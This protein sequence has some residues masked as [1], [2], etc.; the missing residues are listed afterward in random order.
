MEF[1]DRRP[2]KGQLDFWGGE[3]PGEPAQPASTDPAR[4]RR[5]ATK[6]AAHARHGSYEKR[7][8]DEEWGD[9]ADPGEGHHGLPQAG[10]MNLHTELGIKPG[11]PP[12][13]ATYH[14]SSPSARLKHSRVEEVPIQDANGPTIKTHQPEVSAQRLHELFEHPETGSNP[15]LGRTE[16]PYAYHDPFIGE[17]TVID[18]THRTAK[19]VAQN[20]MFQPMRVYDDRSRD[21][22]TAHTKRMDYYRSA[23]AGKTHVDPW[24]VLSERQLG[25]SLPPNSLY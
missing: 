15:R 10:L 18:G 9:I 24:K 13:W 20:Q 21:A 8:Q 6:A 3:H 11:A 14:G 19:A 22:M 1:N 16:L 25:H 5:L 4:D 7:T 2:G 17:H 23:A 12:Q